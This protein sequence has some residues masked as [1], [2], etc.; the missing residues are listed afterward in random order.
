MDLLVP[1]LYGF[2]DSCPP[3]YVVENRIWDGYF[4]RLL[5]LVW[6]QRGG[7]S[8]AVRSVALV[9]EFSEDR[10]HFASILSKR[11]EGAPVETISYGALTLASRLWGLSR[12]DIEGYVEEV[13]DHAMKWAV[14][15]LSGGP[16][17]PESDIEL[18]RELG[19]F[20]AFASVSQADS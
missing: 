19:R 3:E 15:C 14:H 18:L 9:F 8:K 20:T 12:G 16:K 5:E 2:L 13:T 10:T 6:K 1:L 17:V 7:S 4:S 11:L